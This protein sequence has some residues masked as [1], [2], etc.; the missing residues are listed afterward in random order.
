MIHI[1]NLN[2]IRPEKLK[3]KLLC[4]SSAKNWTVTS[5]S[6]PCDTLDNISDF[7][8]MP[9]VL[10]TSFPRSLRIFLGGKCSTLEEGGL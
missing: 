10:S 1:P 8:Q 7:A 2:S 3:K 6:L 9:S 5:N 4:E